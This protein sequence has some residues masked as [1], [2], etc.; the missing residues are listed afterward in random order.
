MKTLNTQSLFRSVSRLSIVAT[1]AVTVLVSG[2]AV[3]GKPG[4]TAQQ[5]IKVEVPVTYSYTSPKHVDPRTGNT[6]AYNIP[7]DLCVGFPVSFSMSSTDNIL[8]RPWI[9]D[10]NFSATISVLRGKAFDE[11]DA[12]L[13]E[14]VYSPEIPFHIIDVR[15]SDTLVVD[16]WGDGTERYKIGF[17]SCSLDH[18]SEACFYNPNQE[19]IRMSIAPL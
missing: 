1:L 8:V 3:A 19:V 17:M 2:Q 14:Q 9:M 7:N 6:C 10:W 16:V 4:S 12:E 11:V 18:D 5:T 13:F 15:F